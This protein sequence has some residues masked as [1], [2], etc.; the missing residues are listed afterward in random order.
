MMMNASIIR[1][2]FLVLLL[3]IIVSMEKLRL[4]WPSTVRDEQRLTLLGIDRQ[5]FMILS[6][7][8]MSVNGSLLVEKRHSLT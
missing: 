4:S 5:A 3:L 2:M 8:G 7:R 6:S 1:F